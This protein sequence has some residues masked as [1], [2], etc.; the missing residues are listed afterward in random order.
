[1]RG[2][3]VTGTDT[4]VG[5]TVVT[6]ALAACL[7][8]RGTDVAV[9]KPFA[10]GSWDDARLIRRAAGSR[11]A[12]ERITP[13]YFRHPLAPLAS[14]RL[15]RRRIRP[16]ALRAKAAALARGRDF[17]LVEGIGG[18]AVPVTERFDA[19]DTAALLGIPAVVVARLALG[20][21]NHTRLTVEHL[22]RKRV[23]VRGIVL[24]AQ[25]SARRGLAEKTNPAL[26]EEL[27]G[28]PVLGVFP[29]IGPERARDP[30]FL[31]RAAEKHL[32]TDK[33]FL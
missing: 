33:L 7:R 20:T 17:L 1:M 26:L 6:A 3:F 9:M 21:L 12:L 29:A 22:R 16:E 14:M 18:A 27:C 19:A 15:E 10:S 2:L 8:A 32:V 30:V 13:F 24:N 25:G 23:A 4:G 28:V 11:D 5:K 31:R